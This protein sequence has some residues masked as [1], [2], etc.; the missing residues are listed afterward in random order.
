V[1]EVKLTT[2][3]VVAGLMAASGLAG[4][5]DVYRWVDKSGAVVYSQVPP[6]GEA[7]GEWIKVKTA[8]PAE[9]QAED[10][11]SKQT[12]EKEE[13]NPALD[14]ELRKE[15]CE[16]GRQNLK[17]LEAAGPDESFVTSDNDLVKYSPEER[18]E[19]I[20]EA[21]AVIKAYCDDE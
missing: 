11:A 2:V 5:E 19:K 7:K 3:V 14:E 18:E 12:E 1:V 15:Y 20:K 6:E 8:P 17:V 9:Q 10:D 13:G 4:A 16:R 21:K